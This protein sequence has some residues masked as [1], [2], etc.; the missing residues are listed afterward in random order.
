[1]CRYMIHCMVCVPECVCVCVLRCHCLPAGNIGASLVYLGVVGYRVTEP[2]THLNIP[3]A[4]YGRKVHVCL[5][6]QQSVYD[7]LARY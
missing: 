5:G 4:L 1:M 2:G 7:T 6:L 3:P